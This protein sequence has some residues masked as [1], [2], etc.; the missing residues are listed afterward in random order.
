MKRLIYICIACLLFAACQT[1]PSNTASPSMDDS[2]MI[3]AVKQAFPKFFLREYP[4]EY[5]SPVL[6]TIRRSPYSDKLFEIGY[7][8]RV[9]TL[10]LV[11]YRDTTVMDILLQDFVIY[12][13]VDGI[14]L[15]DSVKIK[16]HNQRGYRLT[17]QQLTISDSDIYV[18]KDYRA[19]S[20]TN[21]NL[22]I[23][24]GHRAEPITGRDFSDTL[25]FELSETT[26]SIVSGKFVKTQHRDTTLRHYQWTVKS[27]FREPNYNNY[28]ANLYEKIMRNDSITDEELLQAMPKNEE[29]YFVY[30]PENYPYGFRAVQ[31][32]SMAIARSKY[33]PLFRDAYIRMYPWS[34]GAG[35]EILYEGH[36]MYFFHLDSVYFRNA[37]RRIIPG[38][39]DEFED[40]SIYDEKTGDVGWLRWTR[41]HREEILNSYSRQYNL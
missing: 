39:A 21:H 25:L 7:N 23:L 33:N 27:Y 17:D 5:E 26:Y 13:S 10:A 37:V 38:Y 30:S 41:E 16:R 22:Y 40:D 1:T 9:Y 6:T 34:D 24:E 28:L 14:P 35:A 12:E 31:I 36:F 2:V 29:Q 8:D 15:T 11:N 3:E 4:E 32:D 20:I 19:R 18:L